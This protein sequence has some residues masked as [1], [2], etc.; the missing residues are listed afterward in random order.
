MIR[1]FQFKNTFLCENID[2]IDAEYSA[3]GYFDGM[4]SEK[5]TDNDLSKNIKKLSDPWGMNSNGSMPYEMC[6]YFCITGICKDD[7]DE[8][9]KKGQEPY[10]FISCIR[11]LRQSDMISQIISEIELKYRAKCYVTLDATDIV[12]CL[13]SSS[14]SEGY[15][16]IEDYRRI[17]KKYDSHN[18]I[19]KGFSIFV[20]WQKTLD[21]LSSSPDKVQELSKSEEDPDAVLAIQEMNKLDKQEKISCLLYATVKDWSQICEF[22][23][24]LKIET[25][26]D[27]DNKGF[28]QYGILGSE[29]IALH[30][31]NVQMG[32]LLH[33]YSLN[34]L[35]T[36]GNE[37][38]K[39]AFYNVRTEFLI[40]REV[41]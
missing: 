34:H 14:Y 12:I 35:F 32:D 40:R 1:V 39:K 4:E 16:A 18:R 25:G 6:D 5:I 30:L 29:D 8:F 38:Y 31:N 37:Y 2:K 21:I 15:W 27:I 23:K 20:I 17:V 7:D 11:L 22:Y 41:E 33:L 13:R 28:C 24:H 36:H 3:F 10:I 26:I 19:L 9:W